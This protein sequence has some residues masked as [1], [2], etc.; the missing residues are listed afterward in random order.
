MP[1]PHVRPRGTG[2]K[3][4][5]RAPARPLQLRGRRAY[6]PRVVTVVQRLWQP[7]PISVVS[8][9]ALGDLYGRGI[10]GHT[11]T[12]ATETSRPYQPGQVAN[13]AAGF[14]GY[15]QPPQLFTGWNPGYQT[16]VG[17]PFRD[18]GGLPGTSLPLGSGSPLDAAMAQIMQGSS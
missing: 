16:E 9:L 4:I 1:R 11:G 17:T 7:H 18:P 3:P 15:A 13:P 8:A 10:S 5:G 2:D 12:I 14:T 6:T